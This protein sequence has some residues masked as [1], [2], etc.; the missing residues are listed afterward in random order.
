MN[1]Y[2]MALAGTGWPPV[3][4]RGGRG[5]DKRLS[6]TRLCIVNLEYSPQRT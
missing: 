1:L 4:R 2:R 5:M 6:H 3:H